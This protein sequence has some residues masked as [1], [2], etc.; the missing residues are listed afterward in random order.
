[1]QALKGLEFESS[2]LKTMPTVFI[3][4]G[5]NLGDRQK[6]FEFAQKEMLESGAVRHLR[7]SPVYETE[8]V[9]GEGQPLYW[10]A[11]WSFDTDLA[12]HDLLRKLHNIE[13]MA[14]RMRRA[15]NEA[16][17]LDLDILFYGDQK[18][19]GSGLVIPHPRLHEREF[20]LAPF[21]DLAPEWEHPGFKKTM[22]ELLN[23]VRATHNERPFVALRA[24][25]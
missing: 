7:C 10:N 23:N 5:S 4:V 15:P 8:P 13:A 24:K 19:A 11:V 2:N 22:K 14:G 20:V 25:L 16:R 21:C 1:L 6:N 9:N 17:V 18:W 3:G 12:P